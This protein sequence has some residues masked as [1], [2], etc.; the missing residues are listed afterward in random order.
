V[1]DLFF[2]TAKDRIDAF[3]RL[4][5]YVTNIT[6]ASD[7]S[8]V[9]IQ[10]ILL[11]YYNHLA[12][13]KTSVQ[14]STD[15]LHKIFSLNDTFPG[16][17]TNAIVKV[18]ATT[19]SIAYSDL[20]IL[21]SW[22]NLII[23]K[24][25]SDE[26]FNQIIPN[27]TTA[28]LQILDAVFHQTGIKDV[29]KERV[30]D[31]IVKSTTS[32]FRKLSDEQ[33][34]LFVKA[35]VSSKISVDASS[36][37]IGSLASR[38]L[39]D[40]DQKLIIDFYTKTALASKV[41]LNNPTSLDLFFKKYV[42]TD[43]F[44]SLIVPS[45]EKTVVRSSELSLGFALP[46]FRS[47]QDT[48]DLPD[49]VVNSKLASQL[50]SGLKNSKETVR[51]LAFKN[52]LIVIKCQTSE[53]SL[54]K[55]VDELLKSI[56]TISAADQKALYYRILSAVP[57]NYEAVSSN[58]YS[59]LSALVSKDQNEVSLNAGLDAFFTHLF[60]AVYKGWDVSKEAKDVV[61]KGL[62]D[63]KIHLRKL[64]FENFGAVLE[65]FDLNEN[66]TL[67]VSEIFSTA[68]QGFEDVV[69]NPTN[70]IKGINIPYV[71]LKIADIIR[72]SQDVSGIFTKA[73][74]ST[75][76]PSVLLSSRVYSKLTTTEER[77]WFIKALLA[78]TQ[79]VSEASLDLGRSWISFLLSKDSSP[80]VRILNIKSLE[81][82]Y[83]LNQKVVGDSLISAAYDVLLKKTDDDDSVFNFD[84]SHI[85]S[86]FHVFSLRTLD[87]D[88]LISQ[89]T[90]VIIPAH[91]A[92][93]PSN[94][95]WTSLSLKADID[96][97]L[98]INEYGDLM[99]KEIAKVLV[100]ADSKTKASG[101]FDSAAEAAATLSFIGPNIAAPLLKDIIEQDFD[102][103]PLKQ[104]TKQD[105]E[106]WRGVEGEMVVNVL[107]T[108]KKVVENKN[109][110][111]YETQ[112]WEQSLKKEISKKNQASKKYTKEELEVIAQQL[113]K[114]S[115]I[116]A[117]VTKIY[118]S[119]QRS[120]GIIRALSKNGDLLENGKTKWVSSSVDGLLNVIAVPVTS[121]LIG[122]A[123]TEAFL[124]LSNVISSKLSQLKYFIGVATLRIKEIGNL[125]DDLKQEPLLDLISRVLFKVKFASD[126]Q[127]FDLITLTYILPLLTAVLEQG[128]LVSIK[129]AKKPVSKNDEFFE[130]DK[131]EEQLLLSIE[132]ISNHAEEFKNP[133][134]PRSQIF[135]VLLSLLALPAK[136]RLA[137]DCLLNLCQ[138]V[139]IDFT[140]ADLKLLF[141]G[142]L[143]PETFV[144]NTI[145]EALDQEF[146]LSELTFADEIWIACHDNDETNAELA[147]T[148]WEENQF[149][150]SLESVRS[151]YNF[152]D[153]NDSGLRL[154]AGKALAKAIEIVVN[155]Q[156]EDFGVI[157]DELLELYSEK[158]RP[159]EPILDRFGLIIKSSQDQKD[160]WEVRSGVGIA[161][162]LASSLFVRN[163]LVSKF[164]E[165]IIKE[166]ALADRESIVSEE[167]KEAAI[168]II[169][170]HGKKN[171]ETLI[172][173]FE[174]T[175]AAP[176]TADSTGETIKENVVIIYGSLARHLSADDPRL[177]IM[178]ERLLKTLNTPSERVQQAIADVIAPLVPLF[179]PKV[180]SYV[181]DLFKK[182]FTSPNKSSRRGAAY[183]IAGLTKGYGIAAVSE[184]DIIR[185]LSDA[186]E[187]KK[188]PIRRESVAVALE[189]LSKSVG[190]F[191]EPYV[192]EILPLLLKSLGD[193]T[194]EVRDAATQSAKVIMQ[195]TTSYGVKKLIPL[196]IE[197]LD[198]ISW[199]S[200][201]GSVEL[202]GSMAYLDPTQLSASLSTIVP[203]IVGVL[204]DS[205]KEVRK[206]ADLSLKRFGD[207]IR[208]PEIHALV[209]VLINAIG[210]P[211]KYTEDALDALIKTQFV[212][213]IDGPSL[214]LIIHVI[215]RGMKDRSANTKRKACQIVGN[216]AILVDPK[217]LSPYLHQLIE[218]LEIAMVDPVANTRATAARALGSLVEKLGE[219]QFPGLI[220]KLIDTLGDESKAGD[221]LGSAQ[222]LA[223]VVSGLGL[224][225]LEELLP[226]I[227]KGATSPRSSSRAGF[228][229]L[230]LFLPVGFGSQF[231]PYIS[232]IIPAILNGLADTDESIRA[233]ALKAG[234]LIVKNYAAKAVDLLLPELE[235]GLLDVNHRIRLSSVE[236]TGDLLFQITGLSGKTEME[237]ESEQYG[238]VNTRLLDVLGQERRDKVL[239]LLFICRSDTALVVRNAAVDIWKALVANTPKT[240]K[241]ILTSL[242]NIIVRRLANADETQR[243]I[244]AQTLG[245]LVRRVGSNALSQLLPTLQESLESSDDDAKQ[246]I[247][248]AVHELIESSS[249]NTIF[250]YQDIFVDIIRSA[251][252]SSSESVR[253]A[254]AASFDSFQNVVGKVAVD[255]IIPPLLN[256]LQSPDSENAL[257]AL[258]EIM[259]TK[260]EIIF[261]ILIPTLLES[262]IDAFR[263]NALGSMA[264]VAG[265]ALIKRL[266]SVINAL[267][268][269]LIR[270]DLDEETEQALKESFDKIVLSV[271]THEGLHP[272]LQQF[273]SL[274]K[275]DD[276]KARAVVYQRLAPFFTET[277][278]DYTIYTQDIVTQCILSLDDK[279]EE[280]VKNDLLAL[281]SIVKNQSKESLERL[282]KPAREALSLTGLSG[283]DL[284]AFTL[285]KGPNAIL[286]IFL[287][288]LMYG[289]GDQREASAMAIADLV[290]KTPASNLKP[291][292]TLIT[293]PLIRVIGERFSSDIKAA[294][295]YAL[296]MLFEK[297]PQFLR[298]FIPQ[299]Q[300]TFVKSLSDATN[301]TL[302]LRAAKALGI[303]IEYQARVD[304]LVS[305]LTVGA[306]NAEDIGV[307]TAMLK[308][309]LEVIT[310][311]GDKLSEASK[312]GILELVE[313]E[314]LEADDKLAVAYARLV[315]SLSRILT[316]EEATQILKTKVLETPLEGDDS[317]KFAILTLNAFLRDAPKH[318]FNTGLLPSIVQTL[319]DASNAS[320]AYISD[321]ATVAIGK[322]LL[323]NG[324][325]GSPKINEAEEQF[326]VSYRLIADLAKQLAL[327]TLRPISNSLD[328]RRL[329]L[330]VIRTVA[331]FQ[332]T[333]FTSHLDI[334]A[335]SVFSCVRDVIIPIKLAA[336]KA[337]LSLFSLVE[338]NTLEGFNKWFGN[339]S[340][341]GSTV[342]NAIGG[343]VQLRSI[344]DYTKRVGVRLAGIER[345]R[346]E[347]GGDAETLYSDRIEDENEI[348]AVGGVD[349]TKV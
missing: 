324:T 272:L 83:T 95:S 169:K 14:Q 271:E 307:K 335:P 192:I 280:V 86:A 141:S 63:L 221:R 182:L 344:S 133:V 167:F 254:A 12:D 2:S 180:G 112:K 157:L 186:A 238:A 181:D 39:N 241:E 53:A 48:I 171:V 8:L 143:T 284:H 291:L 292:V 81:K 27:L 94:F 129:N 36:T 128:K 44:N 121:D 58:I 131:E 5:T 107:E 237:E 267:V 257:L 91:H 13:S 153:Q 263:A 246:G 220:P 340:E 158:S 132:I 52:F 213:Y 49:C 93:L 41:P 151:L 334:L 239:S 51:E 204:N 45:L 211:A 189:C 311:T 201:K 178:V 34:S 337:Y 290:S 205:H 222:A 191:F 305:E 261:P 165:F 18:S 69:A 62:K 16:T 103:A 75:D 97:A 196:A 316:S 242:T 146:D 42:P 281:T 217:D 10:A 243:T 109:T 269:E 35:A 144:R 343:V 70:N 315:G 161:L 331:R 285:P 46:L 298:P 111:D 147:A 68:V 124:S 224:R 104:L 306:R 336:E 87:S 287:H 99:V 116:R 50:V 279:D 260:S 322:L 145:L 127:P 176:K 210:D 160:T 264:E 265:S 37:L 150:V 303:L 17:F 90:K 100:E 98:I 206:A 218:E 293:G 21:S 38:N 67:F 135:N 123:V 301:E 308:A 252:V 234:R 323:L 163:D 328:T 73:L 130:E 40:E 154:S 320:S 270:D 122:A 59:S 6:D 294:I 29:H 212:H 175:L 195:N 173:I 346:I 256:L 209:P 89:L 318:I 108:A 96:P 236:L 88:I 255:E 101:V 76:K 156:G 326:E 296:S 332:P 297:V 106:I 179:K 19:R 310:K 275:G 125:D 64:W 276:S 134:I 7:K 262:P 166:K 232:Q 149:S 164:I 74:E 22:V 120:I 57:S 43:T 55:I 184:F 277:K 349:L 54:A 347:A 266:T 71:V 190:K 85:A 250:E 227:L 312:H 302:R 226:T 183:G 299:L 66:L 203:E 188:N 28:K 20:N 117:S 159:P 77:S 105:I 274:I 197:N 110:K 342:E 148:I 185:H 9:S 92:S 177:S 321:N 170:E 207:V 313:K 253:E 258:Q 268:A 288:G 249:T 295:L 152:L 345:E 259:T 119:L 330:V 245:D 78:T 102:V 325:K 208:N 155:D 4:D 251:L 174:S 289:S 115:V 304:P 138:Y 80:E 235:S 348:W 216:M 139:S 282:V 300:R 327:L 240:V 319:I 286:P 248:I 56:K 1:K 82:A 219:E 47:L 65:S 24:F 84:Y 137:K 202:L 198:E 215:H 273:L 136:A 278:L 341:R 113:S 72:E 200:K 230:L 223:E 25:S 79:S 60:S 314:I 228:L 33:I 317:S 338:D 3:G 15:L 126:Q 118:N 231:S 32:S 172:P 199:R 214:A 225:K 283:E 30:R 333:L 233:T 31:L 168:S 194:A 329:S 229:P 247:C 187:D 309:L 142:L 193:S 339:I 244:A 140:T 61:L 162:K 114:E 26:K 11:S 23:S